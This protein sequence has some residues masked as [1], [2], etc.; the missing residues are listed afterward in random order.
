MSKISH[1]SQLQHMIAFLLNIVIFLYCF[2]LW[3][4]LI[5]LCDGC[6]TFFMEVYHQGHG[7]FFLGVVPLFK[8][9]TICCNY[10]LPMVGMWAHLVLSY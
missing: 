8:Y 1:H 6:K 7:I 2:E 9:N 3:K 5:P 10:T 4:P